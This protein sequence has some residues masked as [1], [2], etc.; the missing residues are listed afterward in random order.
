V[1]GPTDP[2]TFSTR[3]L[4]TL[5]AFDRRG[6]ESVIDDALSH[7]IDGLD[8]LDKVIAPAMHEV[9]RRWQS[10]EITVADEHLATLIAHATL[11]RIYANLVTAESRSRGTVLLA[12]AEGEEHVLGLRMV[13]DVL[14]GSGYDVCNVGGS[15]PPAWL[16]AAVVRRRPVLVGL[17]N[18][19]AGA[20]AVRRSIAAVRSVD[21]EVVIL[22][23]GGDGSQGETLDARTVACDSARGALGAAEGMLGD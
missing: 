7:D 17:A 20:G 13:A 18:T 9:G 6:A 21:P 8:L 4:V 1:S 22:L 16:A 11:T 2:G 15:L 3:L 23:G 19:M 5:L 10:G 14:D 12:G